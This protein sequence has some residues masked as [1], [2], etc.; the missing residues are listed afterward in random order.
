MKKDE[1]T[2]EVIKEIAL[3]SIVYIDENGIDMNM[4]K[5]RGW[6]VVKLNK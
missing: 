1:N 4:C 6:I 3:K 2:T 5:D